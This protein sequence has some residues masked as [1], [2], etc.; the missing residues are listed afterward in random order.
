MSARHGVASNRHLNYFEQGL[1]RDDCR[2]ILTGRLDY[3]YGTVRPD[4]DSRTTRTVCCHIFPESLS[5]IAFGGTGA[6]ERQVASVW[7]ILE[8]F[9]YTDVC[10]QLE[11]R[12]GATEGADFHRMENI[13]TLD[14][15]IH[16]WFDDLM[17]WLEEVPGE[18]DCYY[19]RLAAPLTHCNAGIPEKVQFVAH[20]DHPLP[21]PRLLQIH[22]ACCRIAQL[23]GAA[24]HLDEILDEAEEIKVLDPGGSSAR[25]LEHSLLRCGGSLVTPL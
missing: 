18:R 10:A 17:V 13:L 20:S 3:K 8:R 19:I 11:P 12:A 7:T 22:A 16:H 25:A 9:G 1:V 24:K 15:V 14:M 6:E 4:D 2:C 21:S 23:S 5:N